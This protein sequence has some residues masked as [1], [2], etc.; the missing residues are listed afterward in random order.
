[1]RNHFILLTAI[2]FLHPMIAQAAGDASAGAKKAQTCAA[3]HGADGNSINPVWPSLAG[4]HE[5]YI[6][7]Q[8][9][10]F[11]NGKREN[12]Q[13]SP[14]A[15]NLG[16]Q[17][18]LDLAAYFSSQKIK[19]G[20]A[21]PDLIASG[22]KIYRAGNIDTGVPACMACH[23]PDGRGN[24][25]ARYPATGGQHA[26]YSQTQLK[27]FHDGLRTN[28]PNEIMRTLAA[29]MTDDEMR[30]VSEYMQGL[31]ASGK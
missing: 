28:D 6:L 16:E 27:A 22:Q 29:R 7:K 5:E 30:A 23:G 18:M 11:K 21:A 10:D 9:Q 12:V 24:P 26:A 2:L 1:M 20:A 31:H 25:A 14:M 4:Q 8:L 15:A 17:D 19:P 3:C 13:M